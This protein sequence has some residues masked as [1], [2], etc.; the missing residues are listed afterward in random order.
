MIG[1]VEWCTTVLYT[2]QCNIQGLNT[3]S[4]TWLDR[5][6]WTEF[7]LYLAQINEGNDDMDKPVLADR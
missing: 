2:V 6:R 7:R 1:L 3:I 4:A 5:G